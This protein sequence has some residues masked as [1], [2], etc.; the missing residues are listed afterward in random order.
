MHIHPSIDQNTPESFRNPSAA[1]EYNPSR[2]FQAYLKRGDRKGK[3]LCLGQE[4]RILQEKYPEFRLQL[5][6]TIR[7]VIFA[8]NRTPEIDKELVVDALRGF[9]D[10]VPAT[11][12][13]IA[14]ETGLPEE[15]V[16]V[17]L[18]ELHSLK[19]VVTDYKGGQME[20]W[21]G[22][23]RIVY[24]FLNENDYRISEMHR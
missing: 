14:D 3:S 21:D 19:V 23:T 2:R 6:T 16:K 22:G 8:G 1:A 18:E 13:E 24:Y 4:L 5:K 12:E 9:S 17:I 20:T 10:E 11:I 7:E 15:D